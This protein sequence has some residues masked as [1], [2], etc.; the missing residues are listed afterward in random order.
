MLLELNANLSLIIHFFYC[1]DESI[2]SLEA[3]M[4]DNDVVQ[5]EHDLLSQYLD[6]QIN[7]ESK[8]SDGRSEEQFSQYD[9]MEECSPP[10]ICHEFQTARLFLSHFGFLNLEAKTNDESG[11]CGLT[12]LDPTVSG[13]CTDLESLDHISPRTCDTVHI[14]Y[15]KAG[16]R[17]PAEIVSNVVCRYCKN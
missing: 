11:V 12:A 1:R 5:G 9:K 17:N 15:V 10:Q 14:F 7:L 6:R 4:N 8:T 13:F 3:V 16:Q 2:P